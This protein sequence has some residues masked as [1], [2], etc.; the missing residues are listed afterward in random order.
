MTF[1]LPL[2]AGLF[3]VAAVA[4]ADDEHPSAGG[5]YPGPKLDPSIPWGSFPSCDA[6]LATLE[7]ASPGIAAAV[8]S[9]LSGTDV[10]GLEKVAS[11][12][13]AAGVMLASPY[14]EA[15]KATANCVRLRIAEI[16]AGKGGAAGPPTWWNVPGSVTSPPMGGDMSSMAPTYTDANGSV[17]TLTQDG[18]VPFADMTEAAWSAYKARGDTSIFPPEM[19]A[20]SLPALYDMIEAYA[21][22]FPTAPGVTGTAI[23]PASGLALRTSGNAFAPQYSSTP[24]YGSS[25]PYGAAPAGPSYGSHPIGMSSYPMGG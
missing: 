21:A 13:D 2:L 12:L 17:W 5:P 22:N 1:L 16:K 8:H 14:G 20:P 4:G 15:A 10:A 3:A 7:K 19:S 24:V 6:A 11:S 23:S 9:A 25:A 18:G